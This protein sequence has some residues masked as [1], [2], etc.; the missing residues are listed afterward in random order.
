M[1]LVD[2]YVVQDSLKKNCSEFLTF[3]VKKLQ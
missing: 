3:T 1:E 2:Y